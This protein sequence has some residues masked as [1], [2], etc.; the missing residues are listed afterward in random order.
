MSVGLPF[1]PRMLNVGL[2]KNQEMI[3][4]PK[5]NTEPSENVIWSVSNFNLEIFLQIINK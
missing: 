1:L 5:Q 3:V 4:I 2:K